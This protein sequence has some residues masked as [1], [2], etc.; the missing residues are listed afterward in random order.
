MSYS[1]WMS[2]H[3]SSS[4]N[5]PL[6]RV[7]SCL[8]S[9]RSICSR[10][11]SKFSTVRFGFECWS[12]SN[13]ILVGLCESSL[14]V[15]NDSYTSRRIPSLY[16]K[17]RQFFKLCFLWFKLSA[18]SSKT[19]E[20]STTTSFTKSE[21][22]LNKQITIRVMSICASWLL[23]QEEQVWVPVHSYGYYKTPKI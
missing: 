5:V 18:I 8:T 10:P 6:P 1:S 23:K 14:E 13:M 7:T 16:A 20:P 22:V 15:S 19:S 4:C 11:S 21:S 3:A 17:W 12:H 9:R 2:L